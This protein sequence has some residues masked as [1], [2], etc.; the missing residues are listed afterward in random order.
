MQTMNTE[1]LVV[2]DPSS[3]DGESAL[4]FALA[5]GRTRV[6]L[7]VSMSGPSSWALHAFADSEEIDVA[8]A[9]DIY[10]AQVADRMKAQGVDT[11]SVAVTGIDVA[12]DLAAYAVDIGASLIAVPSGGRVL[13]PADL[14]RAA[15]MAGVPIAVVPPQEAAA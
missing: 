11:A 7:L 4:R 12:A 3:D 10:L 14:E 15:R 8:E 1:V 5:G 2:L 9:A 6:T 13:A